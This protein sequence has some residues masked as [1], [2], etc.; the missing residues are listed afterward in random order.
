M[1]IYC[2]LSKCIG[3]TLCSYEHYL[4]QARRLIIHVVWLPSNKKRIKKK[5]GKEERKKWNCR[6]VVVYGS[7]EVASKFLRAAFTVGLTLL[8]SASRQ[9]TV[10][11]TTQRPRRY[12]GD[13]FLGWRLGRRGY[14][15]GGDEALYISLLASWLSAIY[16]RLVSELSLGRCITFTTSMC[17]VVSALWGL[18]TTATLCR[19]QP[20]L[21]SCRCPL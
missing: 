19:I 9:R 2:K 5:E 10:Y 18:A 1:D 16:H 15:I 20:C 14:W 12:L 7:D 21:Y 8:K 4:E 13:S 6:V 3:Q 11:A 17:S